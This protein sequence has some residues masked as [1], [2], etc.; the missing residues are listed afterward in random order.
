ML[1]SA[2]SVLF[3]A[4]SSSEIPEGL[5][6][7]PILSNSVANENPPRHDVSRNLAWILNLSWKWVARFTLHHVYPPGWATC[8]PLNKWLRPPQ[9]LSAEWHYHSL[10]VYP[11]FKNISPLLK[12]WR[13]FAGTIS[14]DESAGPL[15]VRC[16]WISLRDFGK[17][18]NVASNLIVS[19]C[20]SVCLS[21]RPSRT[22]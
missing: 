8:Y 14:N 12:L 9:I 7:K 22:E 19:V 18:C 21:F 11:R 20:L 13:W 15:P 4:Q 2:V 16:L 17:L 10:W 6:N 3:V 1:L 5:M